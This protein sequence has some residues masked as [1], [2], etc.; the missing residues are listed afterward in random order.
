MNFFNKIK[1]LGTKIVS[2]VKKELNEFVEEEN[3]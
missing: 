2:T 1:D 3:N